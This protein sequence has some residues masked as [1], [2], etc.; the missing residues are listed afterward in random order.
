MVTAAYGSKVSVVN[1]GYEGNTVNDPSVAGPAAVD[2][3][4]R[5]VLG[6]SGLK[7]VVW[8][9]GINDLGI[10]QR[11]HDT[12]ISGYQNIV[13]RLHNRGIRVVAATLI[14]SPVPTGFDYS[15]SPLG[16]MYGPLW[17]TPAID[18]E[19]RQV[20][21]FITTSGLFDAVADF[22]AAVIDPATGTMQAQY[23]VSSTDLTSADY[24]HPNR[25]GYLA[26]ANSVDLGAVSPHAAF[27]DGEFPL[28]K[29]VYCGT[30][31][32]Y[33]AYL[34]DPN[35]VYHFDLGYEYVFDANDGQD[36]VY[37]YDFASNHFWYTSRSFPFPYLYD[38]SL[39]AVLY[40]LPDSNNSERYA[41][42]PHVFYDFRTQQFIT[43]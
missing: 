35:Y 38:F 16:T 10:A 4:D 22:S 33:Y 1:E 7:T 32:G 31:F 25:A 18:A 9:E 21:A 36:G 15:T 26:M 20:N 12:V 5:D 23:T 42:N 11:T 29:G 27:F 37:L 24:L 28:A 14:P 39:N 17:G 3:L 2:R 6:L 8:F 30:G 43:Q 19:R 41:S 40:Y 13:P 34:S